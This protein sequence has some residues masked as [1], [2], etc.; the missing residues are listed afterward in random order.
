MLRITPQAVLDAAREALADPQAIVFLPYLAGERAPLWDPS[1]RGTFLGLG[2]ATAARHIALA[3]LEGVA[4]A[5]RH[6][7]E[8][9]EHAAGIPV[10]SMRLSGG[11]ARSP[12]WNGIKAAAHGR[13]MELMATLD[14]A[15]LGA[16]LMGMVAA[17]IEPDLARAADRYAVVASVVEPDPVMSARLDELYTVYRE[18]YPA[19]RPL[20]SELGAM[21][22]A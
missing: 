5:A 22:K 21:A 18:A 8:A 20:F 9:C 11:A 13:P 6:L 14:S 3:V 4:F 1:A 12:T 16:A 10:T 2:I 17:G 19:L 7:L 15:V